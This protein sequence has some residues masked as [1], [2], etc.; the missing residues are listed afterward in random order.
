MQLQMPKK[1]PLP[2][3]TQLQMPKKG[4][5]P[6]PRSKRPKRWK[7]PAPPKPMATRQTPGG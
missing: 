1:R 2:A 5:L 3:A 7:T 4:P 6:A